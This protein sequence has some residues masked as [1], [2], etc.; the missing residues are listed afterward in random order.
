MYSNE[1]EPLPIEC[2]QPP[3]DGVVTWCT[4]GVLAR[5]PNRG[6][7]DASHDDD[8]PDVAGVEGAPLDTRQRQWRNEFFRYIFDI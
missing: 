7:V 2:M 3:Q 6:L 8:E 5:F 4:V 1:F